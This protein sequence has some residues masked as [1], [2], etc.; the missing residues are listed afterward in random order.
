MPST[1]IPTTQDILDAM[2]AMEKRLN[3]RIDGVERR[4][5]AKID[6]VKRDLSAEIADSF[7]LTRERLDRA[8]VAAE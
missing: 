4:L 5:N 3:A 1:D 6:A 2:G 7:N 8:G